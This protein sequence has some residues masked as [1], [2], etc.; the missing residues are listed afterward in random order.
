MFALIG[1]SDFNFDALIKVAGKDF[2]GQI[3]YKSGT[4]VHLVE[5]LKRFSDQIDAEKLVTIQA[6][7]IEEWPER[8]ITPLTESAV[9]LVNSGKFYIGNGS[10]FAWRQFYASMESCSLKQYI[11][12][13][14]QEEGLKW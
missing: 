7:L 13:V 12:K 1:R 14:F 5:K 11:K 8:L 6:I 3:G 4:L 2:I 9:Y 10:V